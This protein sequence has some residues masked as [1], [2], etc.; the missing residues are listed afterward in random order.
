MAGGRFNLENNMTVEV[1]CILGVW[2]F[3]AAAIHSPS[4]TDT[5]IYLAFSFACIIS[6][7][8]L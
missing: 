7:L 8:A 5:G 2:T 4:V 6:F 3:A 1:A